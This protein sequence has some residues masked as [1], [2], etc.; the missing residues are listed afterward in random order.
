MI[1]LID[2]LI[3]YLKKFKEFLIKRSIPKGMSAQEWARKNNKT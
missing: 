1:T 3:K 2:T